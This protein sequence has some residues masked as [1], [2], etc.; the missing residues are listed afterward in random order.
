MNAM[1]YDKK[2]YIKKQLNQGNSFMVKPKSG[3]PKHVYGFKSIRLTQDDTE[4]KLK[5]ET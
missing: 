1:E 5:I 2:Y 4:K 3:I